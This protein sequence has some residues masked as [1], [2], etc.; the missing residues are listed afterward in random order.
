MLKAA[1]DDPE[2]LDEDLDD[3]VED[4]LIWTTRPT[5]TTTRSCRAVG[6]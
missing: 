1:P 5:K 6:E 4:D 3:D 2:E